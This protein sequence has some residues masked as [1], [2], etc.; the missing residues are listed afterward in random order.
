MTLVPFSRRG[1]LVTGLAALSGL[2]VLGATAGAAHAQ[3]IDTTPA[4]DGN[5]GIYI[6]Y[7]LSTPTYGQTFVAPGGATMLTDFTVFIEGATSSGVDNYEAFLYQW[8]SVNAMPIGPALFAQTGSVTMTP[9][10]Y[11]PVLTTLNTPVSAGTSY[12]FLA[13]ALK[14]LL[15]LAEFAIC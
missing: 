14:L 10:P 9:T 12:V 3:Q 8:D 2:I 13:M 5:N 4:W 1:F 6:W 11:T 15:A 7:N